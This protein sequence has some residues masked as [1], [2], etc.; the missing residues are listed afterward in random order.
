MKVQQ[1]ISGIFR[2]NWSRYV[3]PQVYISTVKKNKIS[4]IDAIQD[5]LSGKAFI[6]NL[7]KIEKLMIN[8]Q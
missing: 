2:S 3:L 7:A 5:V 1:K 4:V 6:P 8:I